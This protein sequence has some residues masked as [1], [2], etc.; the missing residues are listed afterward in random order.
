MG[1]YDIGGLM[2]HPDDQS[3]YYDGYDD[4]GYLEDGALGGAMHLDGFQI[5]VVLFHCLLGLDVSFL[6]DALLC[7]G[8]R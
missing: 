7:A 4:E 5:K 2:D 3:P 1:G 8:P 6:A